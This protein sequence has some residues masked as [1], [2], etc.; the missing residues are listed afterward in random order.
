MNYILNIEQNTDLSIEPV[1]LT[2]CKAWM[3]IAFTDDDAVISGLITAAR[4]VLEGYTGL[5]FGQ[6]KYTVL[7]DAE[8]TV[9]TLPYGP[10]NAIVSVSRY[11]RYGDASVVDPGNYT[12]SNGKL[13]LQE[14]GY[15]EVVYTTKGVVVNEDLKTDIKK[16]VAWYYQNRGIQFEN[17]IRSFPEWQALAANNYARVVI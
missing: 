15:V 12:F 5:S 6:K 11:D 4:K 2:E 17:D 13:W 8:D 16:L 1:T 3:K 14:S 10:V 7:I 9:L